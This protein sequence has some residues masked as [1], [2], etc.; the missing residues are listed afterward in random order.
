MPSRE[1]GVAGPTSDL[2]LYGDV[3]ANFASVSEPFVKACGGKRSKIALLMLPRSRRFEGPYRDAWRKAGAGEVTAICPPRSLALKTEHIRTLNQST[4]VFMSGGPT[5]LYQRIYGTRIVSRAIRNLYDSGVPY[6]G[7][8]AG[9]MMACTFCQ[10]GGSLIRTRTNEFQLGSNEFVES[11]RRPR[12]GERAGLVI[13]TGLGLVKDCV[14]QPHFAEWGL[15]PGLMEAMNL[16][17]CRFGVGLDASICLE[18]RD[19][20]RVLLYELAPRLNDVA[21]EL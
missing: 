6:G 12:P 8:S 9:A 2:F 19:R 5:A 7:V 1:R 10:V 3:R 4:G 21:H 18:I 17:G 16:T 11:H 13:R 14:L 20:K 15:F